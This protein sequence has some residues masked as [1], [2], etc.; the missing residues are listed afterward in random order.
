LISGLQDEISVKVLFFELEPPPYPNSPPALVLTGITPG[1]EK[2]F[3]GS[4]ANETRCSSG[5]SVLSGIQHNEIIVGQKALNF[6]KKSLKKELSTGDSIQVLG[7]DFIIIGI[8]EKS[9]DQVV[10][11][12]LITDL[13]T[14]QSMLNKKTMVSS[15]ILYSQKINQIEQ[16]ESTIK[17]FNAN[18]NIITTETLS[19]NATEGVKLFEQMINGISFVVLTSALILL[20]SLMSVTIKE[21]TREIGVLRA[22]GATH[23]IIIKSLLWEMFILSFSGC[24]LGSIGSSFVLKYCLL[25]NLFSWSLVLQYIPLS[26]I[27]TLVS[28]IIPVFKIIKIQPLESLQYE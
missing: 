21:R 16:I 9:A 4:V 22:I 5:K 17:Q 24:I 2:A 14:A 11:N 26:V 13:S 8:L 10:N 20:I 19:R 23:S 1:K 7:K 27:F 28:G 18:I 25:E 15:V 12:A 6:L 3:I